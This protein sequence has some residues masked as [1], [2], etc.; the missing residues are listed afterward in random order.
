MDGNNKISI[1]ILEFYYR[2]MF[3]D[4]GASWGWIGKSPEQVGEWKDG[5]IEFIN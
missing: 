4:R 3:V 1:K 5:I 2:K